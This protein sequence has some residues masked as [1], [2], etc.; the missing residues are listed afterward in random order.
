MIHE[1]PN[2][3]FCF[4]IAVKLST[5]C[6]SL[7][8]LNCGQIINTLRIASFW[9]IDSFF[10]LYQL[11]F[12]MNFFINAVLYWI[13]IIYIFSILVLKPWWLL[14]DVHASCWI[15]NVFQSL[16]LLVF[17][18]ICVRCFLWNLDY[19]QPLASSDCV[20][21]ADGLLWSRNK[22]MHVW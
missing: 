11:F 8:Q 22:V 15:I 4:W 1:K 20:K 14:Y 19:F 5:S 12:V 18:M 2:I 3:F 13:L 7:D 10:W 21:F 6:L 17:F 9:N 16:K